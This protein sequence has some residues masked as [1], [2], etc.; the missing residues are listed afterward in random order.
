MFRKGTLRRRVD[1]RAYK[2]LDGP[3]NYP[4]DTA[5]RK[6]LQGRCCTSDDPKPLTEKAQL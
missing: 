3:A 4:F 2:W 5:A 1:K 6:N